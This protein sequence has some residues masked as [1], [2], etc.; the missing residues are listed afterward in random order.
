[1][2]YKI[3]VTV[4]DQEYSKWNRIGDATMSFEAPDDVTFLPNESMI[5]TLIHAAKKE[6]LNKIAELDEAEEAPNEE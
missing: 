2:F 4:T 6:H 5:H 1:M 3:E